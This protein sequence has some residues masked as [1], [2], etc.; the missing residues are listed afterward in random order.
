[1]A[2]SKGKRLYYEMVVPGGR[3]FQ[4]H[5]EEGNAQSSIADKD[6][7]IVM[8]Q[9]QSSEPV[10]DPENMGRFAE[11]FAGEVLKTNARMYFYLTMAYSDE[12]IAERKL[13]YVNMQSG[14]NEAYF[15]LAKKLGATVSPVGVAWRIVREEHPEIELHAA[16]GSHPSHRGA[17][18]SALVMY[19][20][21]F[22]DNPVDMPE[23]LYPH[24][25]NWRK[26]RDWGTELTVTRE[27]RSILEKAA[28][29]AIAL[30]KKRMQTR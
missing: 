30:S 22:E 28:S 12:R 13:G 2:H 20:T 29:Q 15:G 7:D 18:L 16:D 17:Y 3:T 1:M 6:W 19:A 25:H 11:L 4:K 23:T 21:L 8:F 5:W 10:R 9:N 24:F 26:N 14:L 27:E